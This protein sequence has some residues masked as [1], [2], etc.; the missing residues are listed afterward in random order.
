MVDDPRL[1]GYHPLDY[2]KETDHDRSSRR[3]RDMPFGRRKEKGIVTPDEMN[4]GTI[5]IDGLSSSQTAT[6]L[7]SGYDA[8]P[9]RRI[10][11]VGDFVITSDCPPSLAPGEACRVVI[12]FNPKRE[13]IITGGIYV[14]TGDAAGT[15]FVKLRGT[16]ELGDTEPNPGTGGVASFAPSS[17]AFGSQEI[18]TQSTARTV[19]VT[20]SGDEALVI[21][22]ITAP[23]GFT[24]TPASA[25]TLQPG[26]SVTLS[27]RFAPTALGARTGNLVI[28]HNGTG[29]KN[30]GLTGTGTQAAS[31]PSIS[32]GPGVLDTRGSVTPSF[33]MPSSSISLGTVDFGETAEGIF[34]LTGSTEGVVNLNTLPAAGQGFT[35]GFATAVDGPFLVQTTFAI[36]QNGRMYVRARAS[37]AAGDYSR[38]MTF[39]SLTQTASLGISATISEE[40]IVEPV[41]M[42]RVRIAGNQFYLSTGVGDQ[43]GTLPVA[44]GFRLKSTNW[45]GAEGSNNTPHG[46]WAV[47]FR[48]ILDQIKGWGFN[49]IRLPFS[50]TTVTAA[51]PSSAFNAT[52]NPEF[53]GK[54]ALQIFDIIIAYCEEIGLYVVLDHHRRQQGDG[55]DGAPTDGS[56]TKA[57]WKASWLAMANR[58]KDAINVVGA[59][60]HNEPHD[61]TW[62]DWATLVEEVGNYIHTV[63]PDWVIFCEGVGAIDSDNYWWGGQLKGVATRPV[64][65]TRANRVAYSPHEYGQSVGSQAWLKKDGN[66]PANWPLNLA[67]I[68]DAYWGYIYYNNIAPIWIGEMGGHFGLDP[69]TGVLNKPYRVEET[70]WMTN[71]VRYLNGD[72]NLDGTVS[73]GELPTGKK[74]LSFAWWTYNP[75]SADTGGLVI[76]DWTTP[77]TPKLNIIQPLLV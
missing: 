62:S 32:I 61:L 44:G 68:W 55:A 18:N 41:G 25:T 17:L 19:V 49:C 51:V 8:L 5:E 47:P 48:Q 38:S 11:A 27:V 23:A 29:T 13:G 15:E 72:K 73:S 1:A 63:A 20:N 46:T 21:A 64:S 3:I 74:G 45:H 58:Y 10:T 69:D 14:D 40:V 70:E 67:A 22:S 66:N 59:D 57:N 2:Y 16:G 52:M 53:V 36:P 77:Q 50:G 71:L 75:T 34:Y 60:V 37:G 56:Y 6:I 7:N 35:F 30:V 39:G 54:N 42:K 43:G 24:V 31:L 28:N 76:N 4:F 33:S 9:I 65:L 26:A 12:N